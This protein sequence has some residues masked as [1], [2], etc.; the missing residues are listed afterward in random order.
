MIAHVVYVEG[1][2]I[3]QGLLD[4]KIPVKNHRIFQVLGDA[5]D[6]TRR[7]IT[8]NGVGADEVTKDGSPRAP[9]Y[10]RDA[11]TV[12]VDRAALSVEHGIAILESQSRRDGIQ[13]GARSNKR[14]DRRILINDV[15]SCAHHS[16]GL[17]RNI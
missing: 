17:A 3:R 13:T 8:A 2:S 11:Q 15:E 4:A 12:Q 9:R 16:P 7:G 14:I 1:K 6:R 5:S 10:W